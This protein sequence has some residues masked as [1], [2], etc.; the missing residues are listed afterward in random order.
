[1]ILILSGK[2][3]LYIIGLKT[4]KILKGFSLIKS[5]L[6]LGLIV[7]INITFVFSVLYRKYTLFS[8]LRVGS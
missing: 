6:L 3:S 1:M 4:F 2:F 8:S 5:N 7:L